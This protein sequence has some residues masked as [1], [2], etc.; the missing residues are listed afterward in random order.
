MS[1]TKIHGERQVLDDT[2]KNAQINSAAAIATSKLA[3]G[4]DFIKRTGA[5]PFTADQPMGTH[6]ITGLA[7]GT[8]P[9]DAVNLQQL[10]GMAS[11]IS[12]KTAVRMA[13]TVNVA[14]TGFVSTIDGVT[15]ND[16]D[17]VLLK[18]QT[19]AS[20]NGIYVIDGGDFTRA[21]DANEAGDFKAGQAVWVNEGSTQADTG[22]VLTTD[23]TIT[24]G[25]T[26]LAYTQFSGLGQV[27]AGNGLTKTGNTL[28]V[29][30]G[31]GITVGAD[32]VSV[33]IGDPISGLYF[34]TGSAN[35]LMVKTDATGW[36]ALS[37]DGVNIPVLY[38][39]W[40][41]P[42]RVATTANI[43]LSGAQTIDGVSVVAGERVLVKNQSTA[44][45]NG[46]YLCASGSW[47]RATDWST[48]GVISGASVIVQEG[49]ANGNSLWILTTDGAITVGTTSIAFAQITG[50]GGS[51]SFADNETP[52][53]TVNG[54]N[55]TFTLAN[56]PTAGSVSLYMNGML[57]EAGSGNDYT[58]SGS[59]ITY[60]AAPISGDKI[61]ANYRY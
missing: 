61:R 30:G 27:T 36:L 39:Q 48:G 56:T 37:E 1:V 17:R 22:W 49:T 51:I 58:I 28:N 59:T 42:V 23:D 8:L 10:Q 24:L 35:E 11:G 14:L 7:P 29:V 57:Q 13:S 20:Q 5:V 60:L 16:G 44:S 34:D 52:S 25:T 41:P 53:G 38:R 19:T 33:L 40:K 21:D 9:T 4:A 6:K 43:T 31:N 50:G 12:W 32:S 45:Q 3:D 26:S 15:P 18:N 54:S 2:I 55:T 47:T 46:I